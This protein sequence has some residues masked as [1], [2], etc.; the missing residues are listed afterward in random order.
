VVKK[1][2]GGDQANGVVADAAGKESDEKNEDVK[3][4][5]VASEVADTAAKLDGDA[6]G[7]G[8]ATK[9]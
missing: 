8:E 1:L 3:K 6:E 4:A 5:E 9:A 2:V 7:S